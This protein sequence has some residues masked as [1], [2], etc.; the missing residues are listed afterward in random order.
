M[1][2]CYINFDNISS[3]IVG[4]VYSVVGDVGIHADDA[5]VPCRVGGLPFNA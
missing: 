1:C 2:L 3:I 5:A 4:N